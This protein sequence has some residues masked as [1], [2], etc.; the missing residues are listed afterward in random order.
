MAFWTFLFLNQPF[1]DLIVCLE[2]PQERPVSAVMQ[3]SEW[4]SRTG[5]V[6]IRVAL[7]MKKQHK[8]LGDLMKL[9]LLTAQVKP[10]LETLLQGKVKGGC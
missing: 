6:L 2:R 4:R 7:R 3:K 9:P 5:D 10:H 1:T 8:T